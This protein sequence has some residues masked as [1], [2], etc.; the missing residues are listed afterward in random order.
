MFC[1]L[2]HNRSV[3]CMSVIHYYTECNAGYDSTACPVTYLINATHC[4]VSI[5]Q[6]NRKPCFSFRFRQQQPYSS[7]HS[8]SKDFSPPLIP[9]HNLTEPWPTILNVLYP[10][11]L[12]TLPPPLSVT[13]SPYHKLYLCHSTVHAQCPVRQPSAV[14]DATWTSPSAQ[15]YDT[16]QLHG[17]MATG[18]TLCNVPCGMQYRLNTVLGSSVAEMYLCVV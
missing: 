14:S 5:R 17:S 12:Q 16:E 11:R 1:V 8:L 2:R 18:Q 6:T 13:H 4:W 10:P 3:N 9:Y 15:L 7:S